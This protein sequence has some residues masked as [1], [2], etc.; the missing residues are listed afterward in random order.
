MHINSLT[1]QIIKAAMRVH[2]RLGPG[3]LESSYEACLIYELRKL[4]LRVESQV[5]VPLVYEEVRL[6]LGYRIDLLVENEVVIEIKAQAAVLP[7]H[8]SQLLSHLRFSGKRVGLLI[9]FHVRH[10]REGIKRIIN[11]YP[12][13]GY[14]PTPASRV[15]EK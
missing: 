6:E 5:G 15:I 14:Q 8:E 12:V 9:N 2:S 3:M 11:D 13:G 7:V 4:G 10:L 1:N